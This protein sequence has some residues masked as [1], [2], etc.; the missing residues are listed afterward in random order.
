MTR[1][2]LPIT[3]DASLIAARD[4][5]A[6]VRQAL[7]N[8]WEQPTQYLDDLMGRCLQKALDLEESLTLAVYWRAAEARAKHRWNSADV[9]DLCGIRKEDGIDK[10]EPM[11]DGSEPADEHERRHGIGDTVAA[12]EVWHYIGDHYRYTPCGADYRDVKKTAIKANV[13]CPKCS[14]MLADVLTPLD[15]AAIGYMCGK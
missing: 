2:I 5:V 13:T 14:D 10:C 11:I 4:A 1:D 6:D 8:E 12:S 7:A 15:Q 9:C 3:N